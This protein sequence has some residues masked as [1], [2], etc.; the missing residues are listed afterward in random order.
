MDE[1]LQGG[2]N[3]RPLLLGPRSSSSEGLQQWRTSRQGAESG[4]TAPVAS[5][6][7]RCAIWGPCR[8]IFGPGAN[9]PDLGSLH[10]KGSKV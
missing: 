6:C 3:L 8:Q 2:N 10:C 4:A 9:Y 7:V 1:A 5:P